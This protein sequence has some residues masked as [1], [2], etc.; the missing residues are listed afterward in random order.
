MVILLS[1]WYPRDVMVKVLD[2]GIVVNEFELQLHYY[3]NFWTD[4]L[5]K[6]NEPSYP[7][8]YG[9]DSTTTVLLEGWFWH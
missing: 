5:G 1:W 2:C 4:T 7:S 8:I 6:G 3:I 9:L